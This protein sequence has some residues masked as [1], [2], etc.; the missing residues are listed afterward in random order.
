M[1]RGGLGAILGRLGREL[2][3]G[4][5]AGTGAGAGV[6]TGAA[7]GLRSGGGPARGL[8]E[9]V[10]AAQG[11]T[12]AAAGR[13]W[14]AAELRGKSFEDLHQLWFVLLKERNHLKSL[15]AAARAAGEG[16]IL[17]PHRLTKLRRSMARIKAVLSERA[18]AESLEPAARAELLARIRAM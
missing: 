4:A 5:G 14:R 2:G 1:A 6:G 12:A 8:E 7:R 3:L 13:A 11:E 17:N 15:R 16:D 9:L 18:R 10:E